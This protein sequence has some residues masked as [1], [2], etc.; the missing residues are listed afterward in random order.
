MKRLPS[1]TLKPWTEKTGWPSQYLSDLIST[2][3]RPGRKRAKYLELLSR[4]LGFDIPAAVWLFGS[5]TDIRS[6]L[7]NPQ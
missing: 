7:L 4:E 3:K 6:A 1:G 2:R 5:A